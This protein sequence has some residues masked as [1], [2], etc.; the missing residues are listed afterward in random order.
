MPGNS[1]FKRQPEEKILNKWEAYLA[2][3]STV[4]W[5]K[6]VVCR[7]HAVFSVGAL[8]REKMSLIRDLVDINLAAKPAILVNVHLRIIS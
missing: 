6:G 5:S 1:S 7:V 3:V 4:F 8:Y 2:C